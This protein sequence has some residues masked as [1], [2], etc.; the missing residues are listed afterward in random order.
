MINKVYLLDANVF[1]R[2]KNLE[3]NFDLCPGFWDAL[4]QL[5]CDGKAFTVDKVYDEIKKGDD[6]LP[7]WMAEQKNKYIL[8]NKD[9]SQV[10]SLKSITTVVNSLD[11]SDAEKQRFFN[12]ADYFL[13]ASAMSVK[14]TIVTHEKKVPEDSAKIK[15]PNICDAIGVDYIDLYQMLRRERI[16]FI[17]KK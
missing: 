4:S 5:N 11:Y 3:Y 1:I 8:E 10:G 7:V 6:D 15:I 14:A 16:V 2:S 9:N 13:I 17:L 12:S